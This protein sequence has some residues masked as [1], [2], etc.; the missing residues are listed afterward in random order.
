MYSRST[1][2]IQSYVLVTIPSLATSQHVAPFSGCPL[3]GPGS[4]GSFPLTSSNIGVYLLSKHDPGLFGCRQQKPCRFR[5]TGIRR[6]CPLLVRMD[7]MLK[8]MFN[9]HV[10]YDLDFKVVK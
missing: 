3:Q 4:D 5:H 6:D 10:A 2:G 9:V 7:F 8:K 1:V